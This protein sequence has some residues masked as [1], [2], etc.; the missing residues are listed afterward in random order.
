MSKYI[1][2]EEKNKIRNLLSSYIE[3]YICEDNSR[4][5]IPYLGKLVS[6]IIY[7]NVIRIDNR[8]RYWNITK[9]N[10]EFIIRSLINIIY[11]MYYYTLGFNSKYTKRIHTE[12]IIYDLISTNN[13]IL[14]KYWSHYKIFLNR[15][16]SDYLNDIMFKYDI[17]STE[18][19]KKEKITILDKR[20]KNEHY[21]YFKINLCLQINKE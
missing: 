7:K 9:Y 2:V 11:D 6:N 3:L 18:L 8:F 1:K 4:S 15:L 10:Y 12:R 13:I 16:N 17:L 21:K 14:C 5:N 19:S 20:Y